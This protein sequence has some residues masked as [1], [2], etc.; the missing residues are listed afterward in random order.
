[1]AFEL[2]DFAISL[3]FLPTRISDQLVDE[4]L[5]NIVGEL[6]FGEKG[7][8]ENFLCHELEF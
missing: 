3:L 5:Q 7:F 6:D 4:M 1:M 2:T 8:V